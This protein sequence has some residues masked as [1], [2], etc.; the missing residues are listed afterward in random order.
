MGRKRD[1]LNNTIILSLGVFLPKAA[2]YITLPILTGM[3]S[4]EE[5]GLLDLMSVLVSL[6]LPAVTLQI[7]TAAFRFLVDERKN[8]SEIKSIVTNIF[9]FIIPTSLLALC[10]LYCFLPT[11]SVGIKLSVCLYFMAD[12]LANATRQIARGLGKTSEYTISAIASAVGKV[13]LI[14][15]FVQFLGMGLAGAVLALS[16]AVICSLLILSIRIRVYRFIS[17][18]CISLDKIKALLSYSWPMVPNNMSMWVMRLSD[19]FVVTAVLGVGAEAVYAV[20]NKIPSLLAIA[21]TAFAAAWQENASITSKDKDA[22]DYYSSMFK[23]TFNLL[24][25]LLGLLICA[26]PLL[27]R[28]LIR[29]DYTDAYYQMPILFLAVF[30]YCMSTFLG[31][32]YVAFKQTKSVGITTTVAAGLN[33]L[34][35]LALIRYI[36]LYA[37]SLSTLVSYIF[38]LVFRMIN[39]QKYIRLKYDYIN[40]AVAALA[41][42]FESV[43]CYQ[44]TSYARLAN[45]VLGVVLFAALNRTVLLSAYKFI[46]KKVRLRR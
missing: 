39:I 5:Y 4:K 32:I 28:I 29:G 16:I 8:N 14:L 31:G 27:F 9:A 26:T 40:I 33:L 20:A 6:L 24:A 38:L 22:A 36:G 13:I 17:F 15:V 43:L 3:L 7:Q 11:E 19:R 30:G 34:I 44:N 23:T 2:S 18:S 42:I 12:I 1:L 35:D 37:A 46:R 21:Q 25:G 10:V 45:I 41:M